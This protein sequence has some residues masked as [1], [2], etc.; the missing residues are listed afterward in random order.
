MKTQKASKWIGKISAKTISAT[1]SIAEKTID[2]VKA[3]P[4]KTTSI[5][6]TI[7]AAY[8]DGWR[9]IRPKADDSDEATELPDSDDD[10]ATDK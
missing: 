2:T 5:T 10:L 6:K 9:E 3:A 8:A 1:G 4:G 7:G